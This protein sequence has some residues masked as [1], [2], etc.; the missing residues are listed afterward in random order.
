MRVRDFAIVK[1][2]TQTNLTAITSNLVAAPITAWRSELHAASCVTSLARQVF[3][4][5][6]APGVRTAKV[7]AATRT[8]ARRGVNRPTA[9][10]PR[11]M[12]S[13]ALFSAPPACE[14]STVPLVARALNVLWSQAREPVGSRRRVGG[15]RYGWNAVPELSFSLAVRAWFEAS[16]DAPTDAQVKAWPAISRGE[17]TLLLAPTG[18]GKTLAA[19]LAAIDTLSS[20]ATPPKDSRTRVLY[21]SPLR[22]L[23]IDIEKNLRAPLAG[24]QHAAEREGTTLAHIP[25][26]GVRTGDTDARE[27][28]RLIREPP[29]ILITTPESLYLMLTSQARETLR[30]VET[31]IVDEIHSVAATKRGAH[32]MLSLERLEAI[33]DRPPQRIG[34]SAPQRPLEEIATFLGG[35]DGPGRPRPVS[36]IDAG[37]RKTL[38]LE[39]V[40]P[41]EDMGAVGS[42]V[43]ETATPVGNAAPRA[44]RPP[45]WP[46]IPPVLLDLIRSHRSTIVFVNDRRSAERL[47]ARLNELA[48]EDLARAHHGSLAR[49]QRTEVEDAL[50]QGQLRAI[51]A[52]SSL[53][54]GIDMGAVDLVIQVES[55]SSVAT[56]MQR[57]GRA[58]HHVGAPSV[59]KLVPKYRGDL[60]QMAVVTEGMLRADIEATR[61]LRNPLDVLAQQIVAM[62][63]VDI[64]H[65]DD[66]LAT[67]RRTATFADLSD[68]VFFGVMDLLAGR[69][70]S[71]AFSGLRPRVVW[72][73]S[74]NTV[75]AREGA[76]RIAITSG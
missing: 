31:V 2:P 6:I 75:R 18:S 76:G 64:W 22:A 45:I 53:E 46:S 56:G 26:V 67:V 8:H 57:I 23:A 59:G 28:R 51:V 55:P 62:T 38:D 73:R 9:W 48:E 14:M 39:V 41:I 44:D 7:A 32:L 16:F 40:V 37:L 15:S 47:A 58:G 1:L 27:R 25:T 13:M 60:L 10:L 3:S 61:Y 63:A 54:L 50:K 74:A 42:P 21:I 69:Y 5:A 66:L 72:D 49:E 4:T 30:S 35:F 65:V 11:V 19:F 43:A 36:V 33:A 12:R 20:T 34:L 70:P 29:D 68:D 17:H 24:I 71:D 52:T